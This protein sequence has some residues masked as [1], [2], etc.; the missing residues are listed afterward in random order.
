MQETNKIKNIL[1]I[2]VSKVNNNL[3]IKKV[4]NYIFLTTN[5]LLTA[6][7]K[8]KYV[9]Y[10]NNTLIVK[11]LK[12]INYSKI[13]NVFLVFFSVSILINIFVFIYIQF[14][15]DT[16]RNKE[17]P[18]LYEDSHKSVNYIITTRPTS[19]YYNEDI[20]GL[21]IYN[22]SFK[23]GTLPFIVDKSLQDLRLRYFD[24]Y[25]DFFYTQTDDTTFA[26][27]KPYEC[28]QMLISTKFKPNGDYNLQLNTY[29]NSFIPC[30]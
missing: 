1:N 23:E 22:D 27:Y 24:S 14:I 29:V 28:E 10:L 20:N 12:K 19:L 5:R 30:L 17:L 2:I 13:L 16:N 7:T 11:L 8:N 25:E 6:I 21:Y 18:F 26:I 4:S 3:I 9:I 15:Y